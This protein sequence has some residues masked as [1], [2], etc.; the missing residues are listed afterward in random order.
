MDK[1]VIFII[2][3]FMLVRFVLCFHFLITL[4]GITSLG[5]TQHT[6]KPFRRFGSCCFFH[7]LKRKSV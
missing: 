3:Y 1:K 5:L 6:F 2:A 4:R 7:A